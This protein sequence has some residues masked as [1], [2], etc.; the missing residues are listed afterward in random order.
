M[1][2]TCCRPFTAGPSAG[3][4]RRREWGHHALGWDFVALLDSPTRRDLY[5]VSM[6]TPVDGWAV[7]DQTILHWDGQSWRQV[8][9]AERD[10]VAAQRRHG[11]EYRRLGGRL[12]NDF[13]L[14]WQRLESGGQ[15]SHVYLV[16]RCRNGFL[17]RRMGGRLRD[18][19]ALGRQYVER[20]LKSSVW[21][22]AVGRV[23]DFVY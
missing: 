5:S 6:V 18:D 20:C 15:L 14:G 4:G 23:D 13:A 1:A 22:V 7:G 9:N 2:W 8:G 17:H 11:F 3:W 19:P 21:R 10:L 16:G 12:R